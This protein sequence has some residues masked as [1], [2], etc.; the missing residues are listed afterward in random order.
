MKT[1]PAVTPLPE[2]TDAP[3]T[4][5]LSQLLRTFEKKTE[6]L[7]RIILQLQENEILLRTALE[8]SQEGVFIVDGNFKFLFANH[9]LCK[10][11]DCPASQI[12]GRDFRDFLSGSSQK[13]VAETYMARRQ[14]K[15]APKLYEVRIQ[16]KSGEKRQ[17]AIR[18]ATAR[19]PGKDM[20]TIAQILD[21]TGSRK[22]EEAL[23]ASEEKSR[24]II[25]NIEEG[26]FEINLN[27]D[28][29]FFN[30]S[31]C[32]TMGYS[33]SEIMGMN[34]TAYTSP[35][36]AKKM[37]RI[38]NQVYRTGQ[39]A[40]ITDYEIIKKDGTPLVL[41]LSTYLIRDHEGTATGFRGITRDASERKQYEEKL[42]YLA[43]HDPLTGLY[44]RKAF[45]ERL[46]ETLQYANRY[47]TVCA[48]LFVDLD[49]FKQ[50]NDTFGHQVGDQLLQEV[51]DRLRKLVRRTDHVCRHGGDEFTII[52]NS[53]PDTYPQ[54]VARRIIENLSASFRINR[55]AIDFLTASIGIGIYPEHGRDVSSLLR[56]ADKAMYRA[57][58]NGN[59]YVV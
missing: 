55:H 35:R 30:Q 24:D 43:Y 51:A 12:I 41:E 53:A 2:K 17:I 4:R 49:R 9:Q 6:H 45:L 59:R 58:Q 16:R 23:R 46:E 31:V 27:G 26:Y 10:I 1:K 54:T 19:I 39:P 42:A 29:T 47:G 50:V 48:I 37:F 28:F 34:Y 33:R 8:N 18:A 52:L 57:K 32:S 25:E 14:G 20:V 40:K 11:L 38:F 56:H 21:V 5:E 36:T 13:K 3:V 15:P 44:N 22:T 7:N